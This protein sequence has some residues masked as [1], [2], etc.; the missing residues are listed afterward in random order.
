MTS[1]PESAVIESLLNHS[2]LIAS[3]PPSNDNLNWVSFRILELTWKNIWKNLL[4]CYK[5]LLLAQAQ[6]DV[7]LVDCKI[8]LSCSCGVC[9]RAEWWLRTS[10]TY[11][12]IHLLISDCLPKPM[13]VQQ[14][15]DLLV[16]I[17]FG[18]LK[19]S[20]DKG[21]RLLLGT[22]GNLLELTGK[23][24][25]FSSNKSFLHKIMWK[26]EQGNILYKN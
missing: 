17:D 10:S 7:T 13:V 15:F 22:V 18:M 12:L 4:S 21:G 9:L 19:L 3:L 23:N 24:E 2:S 14:E 20:Y 11:L 6:P 5:R 1:A 16:N 8:F 26:M 25:V